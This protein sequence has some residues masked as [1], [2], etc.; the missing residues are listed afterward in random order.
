MRFKPIAWLLAGIL[1]LGIGI[2]P[3][4][5]VQ[6]A[7]LDE[8]NADDTFLKQKTVDG[9]C[10]LLSTAMML[11]RYSLLRGDADWS[12]ITEETVTPVAWMEAGVKHSFTYTTSGGG[13]EVAHDT[14]PGDA[15]NKQIL[16]DLL[17]DHPEGIV[18]YYTGTPH[19][20]L[21]TDYTNGVFYCADPAYSY[22]LGRIP[23]DE[24]YKVRADN[25]TA[26]WYVTSPTQQ[27]EGL[28]P[29]VPAPKPELVPAPRNLAVI[30]NEE[31]FLL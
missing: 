3:A 8:L 21:L 9:H 25:V 17:K 31:G 12:T 29:E 7:T 16:I 30:T 15:S 1:F 24:S 22:P 5:P 27:V 14:L 19:A 2:I 11:R 18:I 26:Y 13:I 20:V 6:A 4:Q 28:E 23:L 10:P